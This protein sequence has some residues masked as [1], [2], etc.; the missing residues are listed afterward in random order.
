LAPPSGLNFKL[1]GDLPQNFGTTDSDRC[2][3]KIAAPYLLSN[4]NDGGPNIDP[5]ASF[6]NSIAEI[7]PRL[8]IR[9]KI[10]TGHRIRLRRLTSVWET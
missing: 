4:G 2:V 8:T 3:A 10:F 1:A 9:E 6:A 5:N 7:V